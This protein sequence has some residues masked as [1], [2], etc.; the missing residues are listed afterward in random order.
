MP[1]LLSERWGTCHFVLMFR[2]IVV[3]GALISSS[4]LLIAQRRY[5]PELSGLWELPGGKAAAGES[6]TQAL[7]RELAEELGIDVTVGERL[8]E[9]VIVNDTMLLRAYWVTQR[10]GAL[11]A[12]D[13]EAVRWVTADELLAVEWVPADRV[14]IPELVE[15]LRQTSLGSR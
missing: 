12:H 14:W 5:P 4:Q 7:I 13:H 15:R 10:G 2:Q 8:S 6:D 1:H 11:K 9:D 3:A